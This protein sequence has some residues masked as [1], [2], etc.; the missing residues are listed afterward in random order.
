MWIIVRSDQWCSL[1][2]WLGLDAMQVALFNQT[3]LKAN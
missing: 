3:L 1:P 2:K